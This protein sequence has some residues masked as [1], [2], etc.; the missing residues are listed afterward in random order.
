MG[1]SCDANS[2][3]RLF[4]GCAR[5]T[6]AGPARPGLDLTWPGQTA[7]AAH[8]VLRRLSGEIDRTESLFPRRE[9]ICG[10]AGQRDFF[11]QP[12]RS[13]PAPDLI[14]R[15]SVRPSVIPARRAARRPATAQFRRAPATA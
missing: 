15:N 13:N 3:L 12:A 5:R 11:A 8:E 14:N 7:R 6:A 10:A 4:F 2:R 9:N 1:Y